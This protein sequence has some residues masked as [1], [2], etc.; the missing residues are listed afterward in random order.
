V[1]NDSR[2]RPLWARK[3]EKRVKYDALVEGVPPWLTQALIDW[4]NEQFLTRP[5]LSYGARAVDRE[6]LRAVE[7]HIRINLD[8]SIN[9]TWAHKSL[10]EKC[11]KNPDLFL[12]LV[13][14]AL[15]VLGTGQHNASAID[16]L[17]STLTI[18]GSAWMVAP[19]RRSLVKRVAPEAVEAAREIIDGGERAGEHLA[20]AWRHTYGRSPLP[21]TAYR[22]AVRAI[23]ASVCPVII[24]KNPKGTLGTAIAA[25]RDAPPDKFATV[26][27]NTGQTDPLG[28]VR[29]LMELVWTNQLDRHGSPDDSTPLHV[30]HEQ[31]QAALHAAV[32]LVQWFRHGV[33]KMATP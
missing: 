22:E 25:L 20:E 21:G 31:A 27:A 5:D 26:F 12:S 19:D 17:E 6:V 3:G 1:A 16:D 13:D 28:A 24:P 23:E 15:R 4:L 33:V 29:G 14:M 2:W 30:S 8:W 10:L 7:L 11:V 18:G 9:D 32:T